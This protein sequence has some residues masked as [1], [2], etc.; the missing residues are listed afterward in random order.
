VLLAGEPHPLLLLL[1]PPRRRLLPLPRRPLLLLLGASLLPAA[2]GAGQ[3]L[4]QGV[5]GVQQ[6][7]GEHQVCVG[8][9]GQQVRGQHVALAAQ[10]VRGLH[11]QLRAGEGVGW[12]LGPLRQQLGGQLLQQ[13]QEDVRAQPWGSARGG[14][15]GAGG[16]RRVLRRRVA[17]AARDAAVAGGELQE[18]GRRGAAL[19]R[20]DGVLVLQLQLLHQRLA[21]QV[22]HHPA[23]QQPLRAHTAELRPALAWQLQ[24]AQLRHAAQVDVVQQAGARHSAAHLQRRVVLRHQAERPS[25]ARG[26][27]V[28][29]S[30]LS[31][32]GSGSQLGRGG[33]GS[34]RPGQDPGAVKACT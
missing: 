23:L 34:P 31:S 15:G 28:P 1:P 30:Q 33:S 24:R 32:S 9:V 22:V 18:A 5:P 25:A 10:P 12:L 19:R 8:D 7:D 13:G 3:R 2:P 16:A 6:A 17:A 11:H 14:R 21:R 4:G 27:T 29:G 20:A 26:S